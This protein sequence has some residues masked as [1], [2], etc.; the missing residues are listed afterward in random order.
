MDV[1]DI[2]ASEEPIKKIADLQPG[3]HLCCIYETDG[4][5]RNV[6]TPFIREGL[7]ANQK[8]IYIVDTNTAE[9]ILDYLR[10]TDFN[11]EPYLEEGQLEL[12]TG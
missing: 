10:E 2:L 11:P 7:E 5:H 1:H 4:E 3:D 9:E 6:L 8:V 12:L